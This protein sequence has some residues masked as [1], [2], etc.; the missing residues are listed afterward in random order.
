[1]D[2]EDKRNNG[3]KALAHILECSFEEAEKE[4]EKLEEI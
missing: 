1:M 3:I 2:L 4:Y